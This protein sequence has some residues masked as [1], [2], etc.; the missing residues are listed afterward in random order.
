[1]ITAVGMNVW[2]QLK[3]S[4]ISQHRFKDIVHL[5]DDAEVL[6]PGLTFSC[7]HRMLNIDPGV[8]HRGL[9]HAGSRLML[10]YC[11]NEASPLVSTALESELVDLG[12][13]RLEDK[14]N[15]DVQESFPTEEAMKYKELLKGGYKPKTKKKI[16][17]EHSDDL[18]ES[19]DSILTDVDCVGWSAALCGASVESTMSE[20]QFEVAS[21]LYLHGLLRPFACTNASRLLTV[22]ELFHAT[23]ALGPK[24]RVHIIEIFGGLGKTSHFCAR[25]FG[26]TSG[27][28]FDLVTGYDLL[29]KDDVDL[30]LHY[31]GCKMPLVACVSPPCDALGP[32][33]RL[34][35]VVNPESWAISRRKGETLASLCADIASLQVE[36]GRH[37]IVEQPLGSDLFRLPKWKSLSLR[38]GHVECV[39]DQCMVG[40]RSPT[41]PPMHV[42]KPTCLWASHEILVRRLRGKR[43]N[44]RRPHA[45]VS[46]LSDRVN[47]MPSNLA[48]VWPKLMCQII[49]TSIADL[50]TASNMYFPSSAG[51]ASGSTSG[52]KCRGCRWHKR[53]DDPS[54]SRVDDCRYKDVKPTIWKCKACMSNKP[55]HHVDHTLDETCQWAVS[56]DMPEGATRERSGAHPRDPRVTGS[57]EPTAAARLEGSGRMASVRDGPSGPRRRDGAAQ[58]VEGGLGPGVHPVRPVVPPGTPAVSAAA[59]APVSKPAS[60]SA[61]ASAGVQANIPPHDDD[62][63]GNETPAE[64]EESRPS[65]WTR[66]DLGHALQMLRSVREAVV[67]RTLR[68]LHIRWYHCSA[69]KMRSLLSAAGVDPHILTM[70]QQ[71]VDSCTVCRAWSRPGPSA[72]VSTRMPS[73]FND[74][75]QV[76][77]LF[78]ER[79][80]ILHV[81]CVCTRFS[82]GV[83]VKSKETD[84]LLSAFHKIWVSVFGPPSTIVADQEGGFNSPAALAWLAAR[85]IKMI[86]KAKYSHA[87]MVE[88]HHEVLRRQ[89]HLLSEQALNEGIKTNLEAVLCESLYAK[90][91]LFRVGNM[92][93]YQAVLGKVPPLY[94]VIAAEDGATVTESNSE[95]LRSRAIQAMVQAT[96]EAKMQRANRTKT[97]ASGE[98]LELQIGD[99]V[100]YYRKG[101]TK[102]ISGWQGPATVCDLTQLSQGQ[103]GVKWQGKVLLCRVQDLRRALMFPVFLSGEPLNSPVSVVRHA[104]ESHNRMV[105]RIG[106]IK[107]HGTWRALE[108]NPRYPKEIL[109]GLHLASCNLHLSGV[110][111]FRFGNSVSSLPG[112]ACDESFLIWWEMG[113]MDVWFHAFI[114]GFQAVNVERLAGRS[115][116]GVAFVQYFSEDSE[117]IAS[118][119][120]VVTDIPNLGGIHEPSL[121]TLKDV[122]DEVLRRKALRQIRDGELVPNAAR[123]QE[124]DIST[125]LGSAHAATSEDDAHT[126]VDAASVPDVHET[127]SWYANKPPDTTN[128]AAPEP[129]FVFTKQELADEPPQIAFDHISAKYLAMFASNLDPNHTIVYYLEE[130]VRAVIERVNNILSRDEA[131]RNVERCRAAMLK[132]LLRWHNHKAWVR[133]SR[134]EARN[135]LTSKWVLKWKPIEGQREIKAR[136]VAQGF[137]DTQQVENYA[138]TSTRW[139]QRLVMIVATQMEWELVSAD[140]SEAFL[141][142]LTFQELFDTGHDK[143]FRKVQLILPPGATELIRTIPGMENFNPEEEVL[144]LLKPG[145]GLKDAPRLWGLALKRVLSKLGLKACQADPQL[146]VLHKGDRLVLLISVHVDDLKITGE[147]TEVDAAIKGL[148]AEF[149]A[150]KLERDN[151]EHLGLRHTTN[152]D[153]SRSVTQEHYLGELKPI[154]EA[155]LKLLPPEQVVDETI[156]GQFMSLLGGVAWTS[157]TRPDAAVFI[158]APQRRLKEPRV[159]DVLNLNRVLKYLKVKPLSLTFRKVQ[160]PWRLIA[161]SDSGFRSED[162]DGLAVRSGIIGLID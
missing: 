135:A 49:A 40:L 143:V 46:S 141:R 42:K 77:L 159:K 117:A 44:G 101:S 154:P 120:Q 134:K 54:H 39:I 14:T 140:I 100:D 157:Q 59:A 97:R 56:R 128:D 153:G 34:N 161:I 1:M 104:A 90:N 129:A 62:D 119:R 91:C 20:S 106:W 38:P 35:R 111:S 8:T 28:N 160:K 144:E 72:A 95:V 98:L 63:D 84:D 60:S 88:R 75:I 70:V 30:L 137:K 156:R 32:I 74:E 121:P 133:G 150:L 4:E 139:S 22:P 33:S 94:D 73:S 102:D 52:M 136:L 122:T 43:C 83:I 148:E 86:P 107:Q 16:V 47:G 80:V 79:K 45:G 132:E 145:F 108:S 50:A 12:F 155:E 27:H 110:V 6:R 67:R 7:K 31:V 127:F 85:D 93:P 71:V 36:S 48:Q 89:M 130:P 115:P 92:T 24:M 103:V 116:E 87:Q 53:K 64:T 61:A 15:L 109:A 3:D 81:I 151:F 37:Y 66:F 10:S 21:K 99:Q 149:D 11:V 55:R 152:P 113:H 19:L 124:F 58:V 138:A 118:L 5:S 51:G 125:P 112:V 26:L 142:G 18:G 17:E 25:L 123:A 96:S 162:G 114:P 126:E 147:K 105:V 41:S 2:F 158:S 65:E 68:K 78:I 29:N 146:Y 9:E 76:D 69:S 82:A 57:K 23:N 13:H 131:L